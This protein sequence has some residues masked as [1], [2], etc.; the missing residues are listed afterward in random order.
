MNPPEL[1][2]R[3][4]GIIHTRLKGRLLEGR[5]LFVERLE[6]N[7]KPLLRP[8]LYYLKNASQRQLTCDEGR[9]DYRGQGSSGQAFSVK[10][11]DC[12]F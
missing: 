10:P 2:F 7:E 8:L 4:L 5:S 12:N 11:G 6:V 9:G 3:L 1:T